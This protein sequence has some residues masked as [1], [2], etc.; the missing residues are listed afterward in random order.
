MNIFVGNLSRQATEEDLRAAFSSFGNVA[1]ATIIKDKFSGEPRGFGFVEM[2]TKEEAMAAI[3]GMNGKELLGRTLNVNEAR[4]REAGGGGGGSRG[5]GGGG[6][7]RGGGGGR[8]GFGERRDYG[9]GRRN[10]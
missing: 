1:K 7:R 3:A 6:D 9:G 2:A 5:G 8:G 10:G 4:P